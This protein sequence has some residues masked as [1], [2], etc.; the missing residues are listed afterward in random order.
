[1]THCRLWLSAARPSCTVLRCR[2]TG[3]AGAAAARISAPALCRSDPGAG[4]A[5][6]L[7]LAAAR[8][9]KRRHLACALPDRPCRDCRAVRFRHD[10]ADRRATGG[11]ARDC[12]LTGAAD[13]CLRSASQRRRQLQSGGTLPG[14]GERPAAALSPIR[15]SRSL[16]RGRAARS[17][18]PFRRSRHAGATASS[19]GFSSIACC[20]ACRNCRS[21][22]ATTQRGAFWRFRRTGSMPPNRTISGAIPS[23][24]W[25]PRFCRSVWART[26][27]PRC[28]WS[29]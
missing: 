13:R 10:A 19:A 7:R 25:P 20:R 3:D 21:R 14:L 15:R 2:T 6:Y 1:M 27:R 24:F 4:P 9:G 16:R 17:R 23:R 29:G 26:R 5:L 22:N 12:E 8:P 11:P 28:L 18:R